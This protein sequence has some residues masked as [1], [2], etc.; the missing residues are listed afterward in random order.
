MDVAEN[1]AVEL[2][3]LEQ[4]L[5]GGL[6][7]AQVVERQAEA[8]QEGGERCDP[9]RIVGGRL[10][11]SRLRRAR[12][13]ASQLQG[14]LQVQARLLGLFRLPQQDAQQAH[15][16]DGRETLWPVYFA[17][18]LQGG[19]GFLQSLGA[20]PHLAQQ[21]GPQEVIAHLAGR[22]EGVRP[23]PHR[24]DEG[25]ADVGRPA[26]LGLLG[27]AQQV[28]GREEAPFVRV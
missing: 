3:G 18:S 15:G 7:L 24:F 27:G 21:A 25:Q 17:G 22:R 11:V 20:A 26:T 2:Q 14:A 9:F 12:R 6:P 16:V 13:A 1:L 19:P 5:A 28:L 4:V 10:G 8:G 23:A